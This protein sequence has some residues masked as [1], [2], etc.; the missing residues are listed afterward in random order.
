M[1]FIWIYPNGTIAIEEHKPMARRHLMHRAAGIRRSQFNH[2]EKDHE[3]SAHPGASISHHLT[4]GIVVGHAAG[5]RADKS[6][7]VQVHHGRAHEDGAVAKLPDHN[8]HGNRPASEHVS[9]HSVGNIA[10]RK[11]GKDRWSHYASSRS[12]TREHRHA[13]NSSTSTST[14]R[15]HGATDHLVTDL[16]DGKSCVGYNEE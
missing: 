14:A 10:S 3:V 2:P 5:G 4:L 7:R 15:H 9:K 8:M 6:P 12:V 13:S 16:S 11:Y 1:P